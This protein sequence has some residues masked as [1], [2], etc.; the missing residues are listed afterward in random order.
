MPPMMRS[1]PLQEM[2]DFGQSIWLDFVCRDLI[3]SGGLW[4][5]IRDDGLGGLTANPAV[6]EKSIAT[7]RHYDEDIRIV[8]FTKKDA[9]AIYETL[10]LRDMQCAADEF[11]PVFDESGGRVGWVSLEI[12]PHLA[13][14]ADKLLSDARRLWSA[15]NRPNGCIAVPATEEGLLVIP[16]LIREGISVHAT[17]IF[18]ISRYRQVL[19]SYISGIESRLAD[20]NP[21]RNVTSMAGFFLSP[22]DAAVDPILE[23][24]MAEGGHRAE[25]AEAAYGRV[26][27]SG[28]RA[29]YRIF[30]ETF[31]SGRFQKLAALG[32]GVQRLIWSCS[33]PIRPERRMLK[34]V[35]GLICPDTVHMMSMEM[36]NAYRE[37]KGNPRLSLERDGTRAGRV[38]DRLPDL[39]IHI[40]DVERRLEEESVRTCQ[41]SYDA[42]LK[43][44]S[45]KSG[46]Y[47]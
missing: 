16:H 29:A 13:Y 12:N 4:G 28:A 3:A 37:K 32:A 39:G 46:R 23:K 42:L 36:L 41:N 15:L 33:R 8:A 14:D 10:C 19:E 35:E 20:G 44:L 27:V 5:L 17:T 22:M 1:N 30:R 43:T 2:K 11:R 25:I 38:L 18:G 7:G 9:A 31:A 45:R 47:I 26:A 34:Y 6:F 24:R 40:E 21:V